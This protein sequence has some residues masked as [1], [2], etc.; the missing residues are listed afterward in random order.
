MEPSLVRVI[1]AAVIPAAMITACAVLLQGLWAEHRGLADRI[2]SCSAELRGAGVE[3]RR[4]RSLLAQLALF[5]RR[6]KL[7]TRAALC[8]TAAVGC[9]SAL[10]IMLAVEDLQRW[11]VVFLLVFMGGAVL[12]LVAISLLFIDLVL[13]SRTIDIEVAEHLR[14]GE[15][16]AL[17]ERRD[18]RD[19]SRATLS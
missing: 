9:Y 6:M 8:G 18:R 1:G 17:T 16:A 11:R 12:L 14:D 2:R 13:G 4:R 10:V 7:V 15:P 19:S 5:Q 3:P